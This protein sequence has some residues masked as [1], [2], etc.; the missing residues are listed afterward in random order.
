MAKNTSILLQQRHSSQHKKPFLPSMQ[1][2]HLKQ[3]T[4]KGMMATSNA[5]MK[6]QKDVQMSDILK[7]VSFR[8]LVKPSATNSSTDG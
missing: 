6:I 8:S 4:S 3:S 1:P 7:T 5:P 2:R